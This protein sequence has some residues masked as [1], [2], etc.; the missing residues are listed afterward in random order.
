MH[1]L[2][3]VLRSGI[4]EGLHSAAQAY[5][6][7][8][9]TV[10]LDD[11]TGNVGP[12]SLM[13]WMSGGKP[14]AAVAALQ[15]VA[16][17]KTTLDTRV[18]DVIPEFGAN[19]KDA[20][21]LRHLL[22]HTGGFRGPLNNFAPGGWDEIMARVYALKQEPGWVPG[23]KAGY[24]IGSSWFVLGELVRR[25]DGRSIDVYVRDEIFTPLGVEAYIGM[26]ES[27][28]DELLPRF[29]TMW[30]THKKPPTDQWPGNAPDAITVPRPG[31]NARGPIRSLAKVYESL[32]FDERLLPREWANAMTS[33]QRVGMLDAT[34][35]TTLDWGFGVMIDSKKYNGEHP[36]GYGPSAS[37]RSFGHSGNQS[38]CAFADPERG[39]VVAWCTNGMP[40]EEKHQ[41]RQR[42]AN[43]AAYL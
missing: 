18:A 42:A 40:G 23:K 10:V 11:C 20:I 37:E 2:L 24:H 25:I 32:L 15:L 3:D 39:L 30:E 36:Y 16:R 29:V 12:D 22:T 8:N 6:S 28:R 26:S 38:S 7:V 13:L 43:A 35:K 19:G 21:T 41:A 33:P 5:I 9:G 4:E 34:F 17:G 27:T 1:P 14:I 31:A